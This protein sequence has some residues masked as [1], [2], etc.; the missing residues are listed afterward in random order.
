MTE[1]GAFNQRTVHW[2]AAVFDWP[3]Y[4]EEDLFAIKKV[5]NEWDFSPLG[6]IHELLKGLKL[7][8]HYKGKLLLTKAGKELIADP[9][10]LCSQLVPDFLLRMDHGAHL[11]A[12]DHILGNWDIF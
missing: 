4:S 1:S 5:R 8:C 12:E 10:A 3:D 11:R 2:A 9:G 7:E 6:D